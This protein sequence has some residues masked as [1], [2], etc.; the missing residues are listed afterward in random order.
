MPGMKKD[1]ANLA[2]ERVQKKTD[3]E[4][5]KIIREG[6]KGN[7]EMAGHPWLSESEVQNL[8]RYIRTLK[9]P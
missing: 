2:S 9:T 6:K 1:A 7:Q 8:I 4:L 5:A 3:A